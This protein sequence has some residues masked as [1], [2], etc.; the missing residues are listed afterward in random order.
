MGKEKGMNSKPCLQ[1]GEVEKTARWGA[2]AVAYAEVPSCAVSIECGRSTLQLH[3]KDGGILVLSGAQAWLISEERKVLDYWYPM[4]TGENRKQQLEREFSADSGV[5][6]IKL[7]RAALFGEAEYL[8]E[9]EAIG[10]MIAFCSSA[11]TSVVPDTWDILLTEACTN[12]IVHGGLQIESDGRAEQFDGYL[13]RIREAGIP[14]EPI[15][16]KLFHFEDEL[17]ERVTVHLRW[18]GNACPPSRMLAPEFNDELSTHGMGMTIISN[19]CSDFSWD[20][21]GLGLWLSVEQHQPKI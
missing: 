10:E 2:W 9:V 14:Q 6:R 3:M 5:N 18:E 17:Y 13:Q 19:L 20:D 12:A 15:C 21:D 1:L 11:W 4:A 8:P 7:T 16:F